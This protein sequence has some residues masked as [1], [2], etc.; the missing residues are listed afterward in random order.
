MALYDKYLNPEA[1]LSSVGITPQAA[2]PLQAKA[3]APLDPVRQAATNISSEQALNFIGG[4]VS[5]TTGNYVAPT[6]M[7]VRYGKKVTPI[8][9]AGVPTSRLSEV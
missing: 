6:E 9:A 5:Q 8:K 3:P 4:D 2:S 7:D 1:R